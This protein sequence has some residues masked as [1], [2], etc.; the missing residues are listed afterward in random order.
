L[1]LPYYTVPTEELLSFLYAQ[2]NKHCFLF[3]HTLAKT[4]TTYSLPETIVMVVALRAL[5]FCYSSNLLQQES[6]LYKNRWEVARGHT[7]VVKEGLGMQETMER[8][9]LGWFLPKFNWET[10][11]LAP[12]HGDNLLVGN[13]LMHNEYRRRWRAVKDLR[14][15]YIRFHQADAWY[16]Q[17]NV[18]RSQGLLEKWLE[19][20]HA[21]NLEQFDSDVWKAMLKVNRGNQELTPEAMQCNGKVEYCY[22]GMKEMFLVDGV[23]CP[24]H[25]VTGNRLRFERVEDLL[26]FLFLWDEKERLGWGNKPYRVILRRSFELIEQ[27]VNYGRARQ[28]LLEFL[29]LV[30]LTH[31]VLPYPSSV[32]LISSTKTNQKTGLKGRKMWFSAVYANPEKVDLRFQSMPSTL[33]TIHQEAQ[34]LRATGRGDRGGKTL[35]WGTSHLISAFRAQGVFVYGLQE[36]K[37]YWL[38]GKKSIGTKGFLPVW[39]QSQPPKLE[40][41]ERIRNRSLDELEELMVEFTHDAA[42]ESEG[43]NVEEAWFGDNSVGEVGDGLRYPPRRSTRKVANK[44][45]NNSDKEDA[46]RPTTSTSIGSLFV[47]SSSSG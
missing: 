32:A 18:C 31:W 45:G 35:L 7:I 25:F 30:R 20:L 28:W 43:V 29:H 6:L 19:Y 41:V 46:S 42:R 12:P 37:E 15:V 17:Y 3:E 39:E 16:D 8:C 34:R 2:I 26:N 21:L 27:R 23:V 13:L 47:L 14:D 33:Y 4:A 24:P 40:M 5:R 10:L 9:G 11:R 1:P 38:V 36:G 22:Q 44:G